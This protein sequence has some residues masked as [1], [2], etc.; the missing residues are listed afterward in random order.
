MQRTLLKRA[1]DGTSPDARERQRLDWRLFLGGVI[2]LGL[3]FVATHLE[4]GRESFSLLRGAR[5]GWL[6]LAALL[7]VGTY[8]ADAL[9]WAHVL[10]RAQEPLPLRR[11]VRLSLAKYF[12]DQFLP[13]GG[14]SGTVLVVRAIQQSGTSRGT[15]ST[16]V[17]VR[18]VS[19]YLAY[20]LALAGALLTAW[21][22]RDA[23]PLILGVGVAI[24]TVFL[25]APLV[26]VLMF[27]RPSRRLAA[28]LRRI[29][30]LRPV[31]EGVGSVRGELVGSPAVLG[32]ATLLQFAIFALDGLTLWATLQAVGASAAPAVAFAGFMLGFVVTSLGVVPGGLGTFEAGAVAG[33]RLLDVP[34]ATGLA[35]TLLFRAFSFWLPLLPGL[36]AARRES[37]R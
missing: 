27:R 8:V 13:T 35:G 29:R 34:V 17:V 36:V 19:Y 32:R 4:E 18:L 2:L 14:V 6:V 31:I 10:I 21:L 33:L 25:V 20:G 1:R 26:L 28:R 37:W 11:H 24:V 15:S 12:V 23:P 7:Q 22:Y 9:I 30:A 3:V 16:A 5:P